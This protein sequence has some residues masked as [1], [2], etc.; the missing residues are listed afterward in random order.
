MKNV[1]LTGF[2]F[3]SSSLTALAQDSTSASRNGIE[4]V[5]KKAATLSTKELN[6]EEIANNQAFIRRCAPGLV[7]I[8][9]SPDRKSILNS[10]DKTWYEFALGEFQESHPGQELMVI[11]RDVHRRKEFWLYGVD[12]LQKNKLQILEAPLQSG[13]AENNIPLHIGILN[14]EVKPL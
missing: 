2:I 13:K 1:L 9:Q 3:A 12:E 10:T 14:L 7:L 11:T 5:L 6:T 4:N 8:E